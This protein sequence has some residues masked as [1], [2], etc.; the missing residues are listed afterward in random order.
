MFTSVLHRVYGLRGGLWSAYEAWGTSSIGEEGRRAQ[1]I[2][3][4]P[5][6]IRKMTSFLASVLRLKDR[7]QIK[8]GYWADLVVFNPNTIIDNATWKNPYE[9]PS[10]ISW[11]IVNGKVAIDHGTWTEILPGEVLKKT[12]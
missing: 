6:A 9:Y 4:L 2:I 12:P 5:E 8:T 11:V 3:S 10:G 1:N 7:G